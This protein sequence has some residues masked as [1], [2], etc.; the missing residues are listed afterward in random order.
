MA[1]QRADAHD[2]PWDVYQVLTGGGEITRLTSLEED[3]PYPIWLDN[4]TIAFMGAGGLYK[5][6]LNTDGGT[7][8]RLYPGAPHGGLS[9]HSP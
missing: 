8:Q 9:W 2:L 7:P 4:T 1:P 5:L 6:D 3:E